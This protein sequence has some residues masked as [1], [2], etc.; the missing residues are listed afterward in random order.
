MEKSKQ[1]PQK[2]KLEFSW[3]SNLTPGHISRQNYNSKRYTYWNV[4]NSTIYN[5]QDMETT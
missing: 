2:T 4:H 3:F 1:A 5:N